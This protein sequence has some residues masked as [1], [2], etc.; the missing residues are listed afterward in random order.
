[1]AIR[2]SDLPRY[3]RQQLLGVIQ[4]QVGT[5]QYNDMV[6][7]VG[8]DAVLDMALES[9]ENSPSTMKSNSSN[10]EDISGVVPV[11]VVAG[12]AI[13]AMWTLWHVVCY[14]GGGT[15]SWFQWLGQHF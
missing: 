3:A 14:V 7:V 12:L 9:M 11:V 2:S 8:E 5:S 13:A 15:A 6:D 4:D 10:S 1:M